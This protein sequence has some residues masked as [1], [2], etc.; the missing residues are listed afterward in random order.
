MALSSRPPVETIHVMASVYA[1]SPERTETVS[2]TTRPFRCARSAPINAS[3]SRR[4]TIGHRHATKDRSK[5]HPSRICCRRGPQPCGGTRFRSKFLDP[6]FERI[7]ERRRAHLEPS[8]EFLVRTRMK[9]PP[10]RPKT[11]QIP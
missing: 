10:E 8:L 3:S 4:K 2:P 6:L 5:K 9:F 7:L 11:A 1:R